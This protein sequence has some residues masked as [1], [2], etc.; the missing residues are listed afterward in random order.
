[1]KHREAVTGVAKKVA[2]YGKR[3]PNNAFL[4]Y[5]FI[6]F[7]NGFDHEIKQEWINKPVLSMPRRLQD[8][9]S[10]NSALTGW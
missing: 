7:K 1:M 10:P 2:L 4:S 3:D 6:A 9:L 8:C 5:A